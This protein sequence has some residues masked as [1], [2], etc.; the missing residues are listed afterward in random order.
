FV[1]QGK[2]NILILAPSQSIL[3]AWV[4]SASKLRLTIN[5]LEN[6][7]SNGGSG[8]VATTYANAGANLSLAKRSWDLVVADESH[9]LMQGKDADVTAALTTLRA[10]TMHPDGASHRARMLHSELYEA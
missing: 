8:I 3:D 4:K 6:T 5:I 2:D 9:R 7:K 1:R 10:I